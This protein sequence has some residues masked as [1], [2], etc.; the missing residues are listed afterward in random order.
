[1]TFK[2]FA[3]DL[4]TNP[5]LQIGTVALIL[6]IIGLIVVFILFGPILGCTILITSIVCGIIGGVAGKY[7]YK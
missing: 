3:E 4:K 1:M 5:D 2:E 6:F 7:I